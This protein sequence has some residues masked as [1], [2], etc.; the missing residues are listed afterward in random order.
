MSVKT[1]AK[2]ARKV[3]TLLDHIQ[4]TGIVNTWPLRIGFEQQDRLPIEGVR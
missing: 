1:K 2:E 3:R 4:S